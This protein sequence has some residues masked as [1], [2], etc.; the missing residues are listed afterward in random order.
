MQYNLRPWVIVHDV[1]PWLES[2]L[3]RSR[4]EVGWRPTMA[5]SVEGVIP[6]VFRLMVIASALSRRLRAAACLLRRHFFTL[7][8]ATMK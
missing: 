6:S 7:V 4:M 5:M 1:D 3:R 8:L 2:S